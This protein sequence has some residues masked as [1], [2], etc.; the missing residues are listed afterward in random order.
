MCFPSYKAYPKTRW[1]YLEFQSILYYVVQQRDL[2]K[3]NVF[4]MEKKV[5]TID[6][7]TNITFF[8][9]HEQSFAVFQRR[10]YKIYNIV[11]DG[12]MINAYCCIPNTTNMHREIWHE[13]TPNIFYNLPLEQRFLQMFLSPLFIFLIIIIM[14]TNDN[15]CVRN[16]LVFVFNWFFGLR[17]G[18]KVNNPRPSYHRIE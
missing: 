1:I 17:V 18:Q 14:D 2:M 5:S 9:I 13:K 7:K 4:L 3:L 10:E 15:Y 11:L 12:T 16:I 8:A 6:L